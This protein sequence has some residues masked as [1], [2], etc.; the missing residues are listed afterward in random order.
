MSRFFMGVFGVLALLVVGCAEEAAPNEAAADEI[1]QSTAAP[2]LE[3]DFV[4]IPDELSAQLTHCLDD[5]VC[6]TRAVCIQAA[7][8][9]HPTPC[10]PPG[11][12]C[13]YN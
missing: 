8:Y 7:G 10:G 4:A 13:C 6:T 9:F 11:F 5:A 1:G 3:A 12:G 2:E